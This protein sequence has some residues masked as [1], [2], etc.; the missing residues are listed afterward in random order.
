M[1]AVLCWTLAEVLKY[2]FVACDEVEL[3]FF[4]YDTSLAVSTKKSDRIVS[5]FSER[6]L[7]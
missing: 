3:Y 6:V 5:F 2:Q 4:R 1:V 7:Y